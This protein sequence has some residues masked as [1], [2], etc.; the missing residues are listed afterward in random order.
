VDNKLVY[1]QPLTGIHSTLISQVFWNTCTY[2]S[3]V[4]LWWR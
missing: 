1:Q 2:Q 4:T 3:S